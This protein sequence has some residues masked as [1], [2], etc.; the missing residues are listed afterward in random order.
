V[1]VLAVLAAA[2]N[3]A[4]KTHLQLALTVVFSPSALDASIVHGITQYWRWFNLLFGWLDK[5]NVSFHLTIIIIIIVI[6]IK[7]RDLLE[8]YKYH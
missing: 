2:L 7:I 4:Q 3:T 5:L 1:G 8:K 6:I